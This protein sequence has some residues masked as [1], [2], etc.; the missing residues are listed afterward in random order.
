MSALSRI[1]CT[2]Y[3]NVGFIYFPTH[4]KD[5]L[6]REN[7]FVQ[8][9]VI[10][11]H[12]LHHVAMKVVPVKFYCFHLILAEVAICMVW[13]KATITGSST[14]LVVDCEAFN[15]HDTWTSLGCK[16][17]FHEHIWQSLLISTTLPLLRMQTTSINGLYCIYTIFC[18]G[19]SFLNFIC[20]TA[21]TNFV[22]LNQKTCCAFTGPLSPSIL[23]T[24]LPSCYLVDYM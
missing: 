12:T 23:A 2:P 1:F 9:L 21:V 18:V 17:D 16:E 24:W 5:H 13:K 6:I 20:W 14:L 3:V 10:N 8:E 22:S 11:F 19:G 4:M 15:L 7:S